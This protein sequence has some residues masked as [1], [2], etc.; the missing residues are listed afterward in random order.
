MRRWLLITF[1]ALLLIVLVLALVP[2]P[3]DPVAYTPPD[4][5]AMVGPLAPNDLLG[6]MVR[7]GE[8]RVI[9]AEDVAVDEQGRIYGGA[10]D[11]EIVRITLAADGAEQYETFARTGGR[12]LGLHFD[13]AGRLIVADAARGLLAVDAAG[14]VTVLTAEAEGVPFRFTDDLDIAADGTIYFSDASDRFGH[15]HY[16][17]DLL[18]SRPHGRLLAY[19]PESG[20][21]R[22]LLRDLYFANGVALSQNEDFVLVV[23][24][25]RYRIRRYWLRGPQAGTDEI[26]VDNLPGFPDGVAGDR[27]GTFWVAMFT[28]R[29]P[30]MDRLHPHAWAKRALA[31]LPRFLWPK[32]APYGLVLA[33]D[34]QGTIRRSL[35]EPSGEHARIITSAQTHGAHL[36]LGTLTQP[37]MGRY[38]LDQR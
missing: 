12:P 16:L 29:N 24:T 6:S 32:P 25:Y 5:P 4:P 21:T 37:W 8:G 20:K 27:Q 17:Y 31:K 18:E 19:D 14:T 28:V 38:S 22:V 13:A 11:G 23:E 10:E 2:V 33:L 30:V 35:H 1:L 7:L 15:H 26:F 34:E 9:G 3:I 36:Y